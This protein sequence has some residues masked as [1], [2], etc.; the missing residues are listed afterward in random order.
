[1]SKL[2]EE[3]MRQRLE[4]PAGK[5]DAILDTDT[6]NE[7]DDQFALAYMLFSPEK[8]NLRAVTAAPFFNDRSSGP[9]DGMEKS[10]EEIQRILKLANH[11]SANFVYRGSTNYLPNHT[12]PVESESARRIVELAREAKAKGKVLYI[13]GIAALTNIASALLMAPEIIDSVVVVWLGGHP[14]SWP[15]K[16]DEFNYKQDIPAVQVLFD[17]GVPLVQ[18]PCCTIAELLMISLPELEVR[19]KNLSPLGEFLYNRVAEYM[20]HTLNSKV[21]WDISAVAYFM[22]PEAFGGIIETAPAVNDDGSLRPESGR[23]LMK[24]IYHIDRNKV[25]NDLFNHLQR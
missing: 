7:V 25:Y 23:H 5:I 21:I 20:N 13:L 1:M 10:Y 18:I 6:F 3:I 19:C 4:V 15:K 11:D 22:V 16:Q 2:C 9:A 14:H 8:F 24:T 17:S 12:T